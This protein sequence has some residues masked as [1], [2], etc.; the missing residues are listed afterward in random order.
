[1]KKFNDMSSS[2]IFKKLKFDGS[3]KSLIINAPAEYENLHAGADFDSEYHPAN[4]GTY[5]FVQIFAISQQELEK[6]VARVFPGG[7]YDCMFWISYPKGGGKIK[8]DIKRD[9]VWEAMK[10]AGLRPV[11]QVAV[12]ETWSALRGRP[13]EKVGK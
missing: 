8:S 10:I 6:L 2:D 1:M 4:K 13:F 3:K 9:T 7:K 5:D 12:D 11:A